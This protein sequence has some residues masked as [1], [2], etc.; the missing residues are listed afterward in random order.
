[1]VLLQNQTQFVVHIEA[2]NIYEIGNILYVRECLFQRFFHHCQTMACK[3][4]LSLFSVLCQRVFKQKKMTMCLLTHLHNIFCIVFLLCVIQWTKSTAHLHTV[5]I[6]FCFHACTCVF[7]K[8]YCCFRRNHLHLCFFKK[9]RLQHSFVLAAAST[10]AT[11]SM[12]LFPH[13]LFPPTSS[14]LR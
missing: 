9:C 1:M 3:D 11:A 7:R 8:Q 12:L 14:K 4:I 6:L 10:A 5:L 13:S 2:E